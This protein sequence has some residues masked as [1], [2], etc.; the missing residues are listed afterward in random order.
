[1]KVLFRTIFSILILVTNQIS[2]QEFTP[3]WESCFGGTL[4]DEGY[5][6]AKDSDIFIIVAQT[7]SIDGDI[8]YNQGLN[9]ILIIK[10]DSLGNV[11]KTKTIGG[12]K[13]EGPYKIIRISEGQYFI[14]AQTNSSD[15]DISYNPWPMSNSIFWGI[16]IN[17]DLEIVW[18]KVYG[19][20]GIEFIEDSRTTLDGGIINLCTTTSQNG[21]ISNSYGGWDIWMFKLNN[22]G[23]LI[24]E[25]SLGGEGFENGG[26]VIETSD[27][28]YLVVGATD[29]LGGGNY[30]TICNF[31]GDPGG[32]YSDGWVLKL[33][34]VLNIEWQECYGG[35]KSEN[36]TNV[37][38]LE[39]SYVILGNSDSD[40]G[41]VYGYHGNTN[42]PYS[43]DD[44]WVIKIDKQGNLLWQSCLGGYYMEYAENIF[45]MSDGGYMIVG[46][47]TSDDGDVE[48]FNGFVPGG[49]DVW[50][51]KLDYLGNIEW[52][53]CY[54]EYSREYIYKG[55]IQLDDWDYALSFTTRSYDWRCYFDVGELDY[56]RVTELY[57][58]TLVGINNRT[59]KD[60]YSIKVCP[61]P[62]ENNITFNYNL[63]E[64]TK[65]FYKM[66]IYNSNGTC[67][68][69]VVIDSQL[70]N[71]T[72]DISNYKAGLYFY[73]LNSE[74]VQRTG[75]FVVAR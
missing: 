18:E 35:T 55:V 61:N 16:M 72:I 62:A 48:G 12:T 5:G 7:E 39:D 13:S 29:G 59:D 26:A 17:E 53:Y 64:S 20:S 65:Q 54:G 41:D 68:S 40:D 63:P 28:G 1:M 23:E 57:D 44:I 43:L 8:E 19:G 51:V 32:G 14:A 6:I 21:D 73:S 75:K 56:I 3:K 74:G 2:A 25:K 10:T 46:S 33:D 9:D 67:V 4:S 60:F 11:I 50:F 52:Q 27:M 47:T 45:L 15:G 58:S 42:D 49:D 31:H 38:E 69:K 66:Y 24:W 36:F 71:E 34:S 70:K 37:L 22:S 30:D